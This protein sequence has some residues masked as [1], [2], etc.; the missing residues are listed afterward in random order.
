MTKEIDKDLITLN[1][2]QNDGKTIHLYFNT[3]I[4]LYVAYGFSAFFAAHIVDV[5]TAF[6]E[7]LKMPAALMRKSEVAELRLS[8]VKHQHDYHEYYQLELK[9]EIPLD[10]YTRWAASTKWGHN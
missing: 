4:G 2:V 10:D 8:T 5:I 1:E 7:D 3:E 6:S 9:H